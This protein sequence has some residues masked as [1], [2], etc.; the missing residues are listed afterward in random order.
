MQNW[1]D[2]FQHWEQRNKSTAVITE[3][4]EYIEKSRLAQEQMQ[5]RKCLPPT[6][7][8]MTGRSVRIKTV[9]L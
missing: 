8:D 5:S 1:T 3:K 2:Q 9:T 4:T 6:G 7:K